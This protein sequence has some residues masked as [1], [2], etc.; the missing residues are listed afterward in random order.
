MFTSHGNPKY[1][2][3]NYQAKLCDYKRLIQDSDLSIGKGIEITC[4]ELKENIERGSDL[5]NFR[6]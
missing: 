5:V 1:I 4:R 6:F 3:E 2:Y